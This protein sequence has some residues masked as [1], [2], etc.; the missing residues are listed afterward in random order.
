[1][2]Q[3]AA[4]LSLR[5]RHET[6]ATSTTYSFDRRPRRGVASARRPLCAPAGKEREHSYAVRTLK[7]LARSAGEQQQHEQHQAEPE[8][9]DDDPAAS[10]EMQAM[11]QLQ[12]E[13]TMSVHEA[14]GKP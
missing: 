3:T 1:L 10:G 7:V 12:K 8:T 13:R 5:R 4:P 14:R 11:A 9:D 6:S 2:I